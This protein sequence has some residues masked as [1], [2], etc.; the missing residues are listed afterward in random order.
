MSV[1]TIETRFPECD[2]MGVIHH[3]VY[4]I[5]YEAARMDFLAEVGFSY[6]D[7]RE[8]SVDP[9][10]VDLHLSYKLP[11]TYPETLTIETRLLELAPKKLKLGY[12]TRNSEGEVI[13]TA[14]SLH[15]WVSG[16]RSYNLQE[17]LPEVYA[18]FAAQL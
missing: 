12:V 13:N 10:M 7:S 16:G 18:R 2:R 1:T 14:E 3:A 9:A 11:A 6:T 17:S 5:W 4:P 15:I 8:Y